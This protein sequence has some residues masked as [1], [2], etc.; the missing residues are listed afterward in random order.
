MEKNNAKEAKIA[1][2]M[3]KSMTFRGLWNSGLLSVFFAEMTVR[4]FYSGSYWAVGF[5]ALYTFICAMDAVNFYN[6]HK[7]VKEAESELGG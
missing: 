2:D 5:G 7:A 6:F 4:G 3:T 1:L